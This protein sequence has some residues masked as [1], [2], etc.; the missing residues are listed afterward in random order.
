[1]KSIH[2]QLIVMTN[3]IQELEQ[4]INAYLPSLQ[5]INEKSWEQKIRPDK[6]SKKEILGHLLD[7]AHTNL[8]R[9]IVAQYEETPKIVYNQDKCV[10]ISNYQH[11]PIRDLIELWQLTNK[12]IIIVWKNMRAAVAQRTCETGEVH[13]LEW[14]AADYNRHLAH[15]MH[16]LLGGNE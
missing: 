9:F 3:T 13:T 4:Q 7:S 2:K 11:Y 10:A 16:A 8:R 14:L 12:H 1:M 5:Q 6:W 15:H